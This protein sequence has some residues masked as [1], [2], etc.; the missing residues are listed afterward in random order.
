MLSSH[1]MWVTCPLHW[2]QGLAGRFPSA[3]RLSFRFWSLNN[4]SYACVLARSWRLERANQ[5]QARA[6]RGL[7]QWGA[8]R[9]I[10]QFN[11]LHTLGSLQRHN[12]DLPANIYTG[13]TIVTHLSMWLTVCKGKCRSGCLL[14][15]W[16]R[17][18]LS[19]AHEICFHTAV[20]SSIVNIILRPCLL[21]SKFVSVS[22]QCDN[23]YNFDAVTCTL[24]LNWRRDK[25]MKSA[26][27]L[28]SVYELVY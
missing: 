26:N 18:V 25:P 1:I 3:R 20:M 28:R 4:N 17:Y 2:R 24:E 13:L 10:V 14:Q 15:M 22:M 9:G 7:T 21:S 5:A 6:E 19:W 16:L 12:L 23:K 11:C 27:L 8:D